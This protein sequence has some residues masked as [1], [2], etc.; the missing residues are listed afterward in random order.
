MKLCGLAKY[1]WRIDYFT[2]DLVVL[3]LASLS[4]VSKLNYLKCCDV[5]NKPALIVTLVFV[6]FRLFGVHSRSLDYKERIAHSWDTL[7][8]FTSFENKCGATLIIN[9]RNVIL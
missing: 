3:R 7:V 6:R 5:G 8:W 9:K 2:L 4:T 1:L